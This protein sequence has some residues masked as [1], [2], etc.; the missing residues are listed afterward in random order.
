MVLWRRSCEILLWK[1]FQNI[2]LKNW[3]DKSQIICRKK[4]KFW[5]GWQIH[6]EANPLPLNFI[7][8]FFF[9]LAFKL[10]FPLKCFKN[11]QD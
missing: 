2:V 8:D 1:W 9:F 6:H 10:P 5:R 3:G 4:K 11:A 7:I